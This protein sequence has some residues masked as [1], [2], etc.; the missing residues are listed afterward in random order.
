M[1][2]KNNNGLVAAILFA[3]V[4]ISGSLVFFA[5]QLGGGLDE[6]ELQT[7]IFKGIDAYV[8]QQKQEYDQKQA[9]ANNPAPK[10]VE[11]DFSDDDPFMGDADAPV[12]IVEWSDYE[13]PYCK[14]FYDDTLG[15][16]IDNYV[17]T[18]KVKLVY[19]DFPLSFH[20]TAYPAAL[21]GECAREQEGDAVYFKIHDKIFEDGF[22]QEALTAYAVTLGVD[23]GDLTECITED[24]FKE[25]IY[26]DMDDASAIGIS[27]TPGFVVGTEIISGAMPYSVFEESIEKALAEVE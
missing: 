18:G 14:R 6:K 16:I 26:A 27:G 8:D 21:L 20:A 24:R 3:G 11:G 9:E 2:K 19:R 22:D 7:Q 4:A 25:E 10:Y 13:C 17:K 15:L 1:A 23:E 5:T 12:T